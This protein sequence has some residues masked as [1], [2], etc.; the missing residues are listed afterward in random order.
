MEGC[1][2]VYL[3]GQRRWLVWDET[4]L[5]GYNHRMT[6]RNDKNECLWEFRLDM[7]EAIAGHLVEED[8]VKIWTSGGYLIE[9]DLRAGHVRS[10]IFVK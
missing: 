1:K 2:E 10:T 7:P 9:L 5:A 3:D 6:L 8:V 4:D